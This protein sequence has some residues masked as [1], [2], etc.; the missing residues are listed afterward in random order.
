MN[1]INQLYL[2]YNKTMNNIK[3]S[4][5]LYKILIFL[6]EFLCTDKID[7]LMA[8]RIESITFFAL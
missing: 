6:N 7:N 1:W 4:I 3:I 8:I 5:I 2:F